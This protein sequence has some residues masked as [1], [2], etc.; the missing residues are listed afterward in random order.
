SAFSH[1][2][3]N[4]YNTQGT[5]VEQLV[6]AY[7]E[8]GTYDLTWDDFDIPSGVYIIKMQAGEFVHSQKVVL[9]K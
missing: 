7:V 1:M 6:N 5:L 2:S 4:I 8:P 9:L 3:V